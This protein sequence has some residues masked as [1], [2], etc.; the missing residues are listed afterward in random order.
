[1]FEVLFVEGLRYRKRLERNGKALGVKEQK[2][3]DTAMQ[4][5]AA[6]RRAERRKAGKA[7]FS[8]VYNFRY[9]Y[10]GEVARVSDCSLA[11]EEKGSW[12]IRCVPKVG[13]VGA[14]KEEREL[15]SYRQTFWL[16]QKEMAVTGRRAEV[17]RVGA[18]G[19]WMA[20]KMWVRFE[21]A[22]GKGCQVNEY[23]GYQLFAVESM[24]TVE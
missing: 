20:R 16:D 19:P 17:V 11:G 4:R 15:L 18:D 14:T 21:T 6:E 9:G 1:M 12:M 7:F 13:Y 3:V 23:S 2:A 22:R 24:I 5:T 10:V 8:R